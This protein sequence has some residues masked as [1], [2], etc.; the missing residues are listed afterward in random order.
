MILFLG[1]E[2]SFSCLQ[3]AEELTEFI[4]FVLK[5]TELVLITCKGRNEAIR[6]FKT[7]NARGMDLS[8]ADLMRSYLF[9]CLEDKSAE[10]NDKKVLEENWGS[11]EQ[12]IKE[13]G[14]GP[15]LEEF[16]RYYA[17]FLAQGD[18][19]KDAYYDLVED[20]SSVFRKEA[21]DDPLKAFQ[22]YRKFCDFFLDVIDDKTVCT[23]KYLRQDIYW[24]TIISSSF[25]VGKENEAWEQLAFYIRRF[26]YISW[27]AGDTISPLKQTSFS[28]ITEISKGKVAGE[29]PL[30]KIKGILQNKL[31]ERKSEERMWESI[32]AKDVFYQK[33]SKPLL[34]AI[35]LNQSDETRAFIPSFNKLHVEHILPQSYKKEEWNG[36]SDLEDRLHSLPNLTLLSSSKN[37]GANAKPFKEKLQKYYLNSM[38]KGKDGISGIEM[39]RALE[40]YANDGWVDTAYEDRQKWME[41]EISRLL[42]VDI[43]PK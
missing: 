1:K 11:L 16:F 32:R 40:K 29:I 23:L 41:Q 25:Y 2:S 6:I 5:S 15:S 8:V 35:E 37:S 34:M 33:W 13:N 19:K 18:I 10:D 28:V 30:E 21:K 3:K 26:Y 38:G 39:T 22:N 43:P 14:D 4:W 12:R 42:E 27:I 24:K 7:L 17:Y 20:E 31:Q 9:T 36:L